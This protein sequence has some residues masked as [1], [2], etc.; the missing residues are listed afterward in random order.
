[1]TREAEHHTN[2]AI[3]TWIGYTKDNKHYLKCSECDYGDKGE[4]L[5]EMRNFYCPK[6]GAYNPIANLVN[7][8]RVAPKIEYKCYECA[9][10]EWD[11]EEYFGGARQAIVVGCKK[12]FVAFDID[13]ETY[14]EF[15]EGDICPE[16]EEADN[17]RV[18]E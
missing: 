14:P 1:M 18:E 16:F 13:K 12:N 11:Y 4:I 5:L 8:K 2:V 15:E 6:C 9:Y 17:G 7:L 10:S 3:G